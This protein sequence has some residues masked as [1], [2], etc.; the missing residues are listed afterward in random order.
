[1]EK[2]MK[3]NVHI[4]VYIQIDIYLN[5]FATYQ[6]LTQHCKPIILQV[7]FKELII[8]DAYKHLL[9]PKLLPTFHIFSFN[10]PILR[11]GRALAIPSVQEVKAQEG[12]SGLWSP[13][14]SSAVG[15]GS[16]PH[17]LTLDPAPSSPTLPPSHNHQAPDPHSEDSP[18][19]IIRC[20]TWQGWMWHL[21]LLRPFFLNSEVFPRTVGLIPSTWMLVL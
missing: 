8:V 18:C 16:S 13:H 19:L 1:M 15:R 21:C 14:S 4:Y 20:E 2:N 3:K 10:F 6:K 17:R 12:K 9:F 7:F 5:H 11:W